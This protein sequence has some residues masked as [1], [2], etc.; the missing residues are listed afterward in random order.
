MIYIKCSGKHP[1]VP[2]W[3]KIKETQMHTVCL[4]PQEAC[5]YS[6]LHPATTLYSLRLQVWFPRVI[7]AT[8]VYM[9]EFFWR[10]PI[11]LSLNY[12]SSVT[13]SHKKYLTVYFKRWCSKSNHLY[14]ESTHE[15]IYIK[16]DSIVLWI[17]K[18]QCGW[19]IV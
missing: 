15:S 6:S 17:N 18:G 16:K 12:I 13:A 3:F 8:Y 9:F 7:C 5:K 1:G 2:W 11:F 19:R 4:H 10:L 14:S